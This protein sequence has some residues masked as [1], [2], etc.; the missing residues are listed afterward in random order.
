MLHDGNGKQNGHSSS[1]PQKE[2]QSQRE[3]LGLSSF[4]EGADRMKQASGTRAPTEPEDVDPTSSQSTAK[5]L[6]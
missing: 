4:M 3:Q 2:S 1:R 5:L 6:V